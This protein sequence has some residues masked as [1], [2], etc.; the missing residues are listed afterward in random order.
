MYYVLTR[1]TAIHCLMPSFQ[2]PVLDFLCLR[3][4]SAHCCPCQEIQF[5]IQWIPHLMPVKNCGISS[6]VRLPFL[7]CTAYS[8]PF[9]CFLGSPLKS[10][11]WNQLIASKPALRKPKLRKKAYRLL[12]GF[13]LVILE[14]K[15]VRQ[16]SQEKQ[17][18][19]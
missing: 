16:G 1:T 13:S 5:H 9:K 18:S 8:L 15:Q 17:F 12:S 11:I 14:K 10:T 19:T 4:F 6:L 3:T 7:L 2:L